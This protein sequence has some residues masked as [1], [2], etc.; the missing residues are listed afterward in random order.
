LLTIHFIFFGATI[1]VLGLMVMG[2]DSCAYQKC[3][4]QAWVNRA[5]NLGLWAGGVILFAD[6]A[7]SVFRL[8]RRRVAWFVPVIGRVAQLALGFG[9][10]AM[11]SLAGPV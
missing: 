6:V 2:T 4:D 5:M 7:V 9:A 10:A 1:L 11:E 8:V 3:G